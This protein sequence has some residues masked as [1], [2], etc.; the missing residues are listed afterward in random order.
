M[1]VNG[2]AHIQVSVD[3]FEECIAF[4]DQVMPYLGLEAVHRSDQF[5]YYVG[6]RTAYN[7]SR[8]DPQYAGEGSGSRSITFLVRASSPKARHSILRLATP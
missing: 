4:Y 5:V 7:V 6:G 3:R 8:A 1:E 2:I